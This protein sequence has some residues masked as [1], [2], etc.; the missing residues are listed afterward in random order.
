MIR[1]DSSTVELTTQEMLAWRMVDRRLDSG[2]GFP[3]AIAYAA[4]RLARFGRPALSKEFWAWQSFADDSFLV[5]V[6]DNKFPGQ[7]FQASLT[8]FGSW[9]ATLPMSQY[10]DAPFNPRYTLA[11]HSRQQRVLCATD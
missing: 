3:E 8:V 5:T 9:W 4:H 7:P 10:R 6:H 2:A 11:P 1:I